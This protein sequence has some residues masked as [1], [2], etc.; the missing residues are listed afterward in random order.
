MTIRMM[1]M[2]YRINWKGCKHESERAECSAS[3]RISEVWSLCF[4]DICC[5]FTVSSRLP[6]VFRSRVK[7]LLV[8]MFPTLHDKWIYKG[9]RISRNT[10][11]FYDWINGPVLV[12]I[13]KWHCRV[14]SVNDMMWWENKSALLSQ[15]IV[16]KSPITQFLASYHN[17]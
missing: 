6:S 12:A 16:W 8:K 1:K 17:H 2:L 5:V 11:V 13:L 4:L 3:N 14:S 9:Q 7:L 10:N 15:D